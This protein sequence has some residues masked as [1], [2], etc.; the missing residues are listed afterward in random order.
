MNSDLKT[1]INQSQTVEFL[2]YAACFWSF[3]L[4]STPTDDNKA[5]DTLGKLLT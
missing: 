4:V 2:D 3:H 5:L 1:K